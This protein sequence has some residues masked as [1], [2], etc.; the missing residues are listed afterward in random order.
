MMRCIASIAIMILAAGCE[1]QPQPRATA[2]QFKV[3][4]TDDVP[5][6][7]AAYVDNIYAKVP[8]VRIRPE[9]YPVCVTH[10]IRHI[11]EGAWHGPTPTPCDDRWDSERALATSIPVM[12]QWGLE[13][14]P[15]T[16]GDNVTSAAQPG[17][18]R[19]VYE[20]FMK[21]L[22]YARRQPHAVV[23]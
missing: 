12:E 14:T 16:G 21:W 3:Q 20:R 13:K 6:G 15:Q 5:L 10:E 22:G 8:I 11:F 19:R 1:T 2:A 18:V 17:L 7:L 4:I 23:D 9:F